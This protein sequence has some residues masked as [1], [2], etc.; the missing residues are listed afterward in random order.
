MKKIQSPF[1][2]TGQIPLFYLL[3]YMWELDRDEEKKAGNFT[4]DKKFKTN[5]GKKKKIAKN[6]MQE[7]RSKPEGI[8]FEP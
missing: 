3:I 4:P 2:F 1:F 7:L 8:N 5:H 6:K